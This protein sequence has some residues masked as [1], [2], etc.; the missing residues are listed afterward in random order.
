MTTSTTP[1]MTTAASE[2]T[3]PLSPFQRAALRYPRRP[4]VL[5]VELARPAGAL[6]E[7]AERALAASPELTATLRTVAGLRIPRQEPH[8]PTT[9]FSAGGGWQLTAG[10]LTVLALPRGKATRLTVRADALVADARSMELFLARMADPNGPAAPLAFFDVAAGHAAMARDG[11]LDQ[12]RQYWRAVPRLGDARSG[13]GSAAGRSDRL[14]EVSVPVEAP[15]CAR[16]ADLARAQGVEVSDMLYLALHLL[17]NRVCPD[18]ALVGR[19]TDART[20]MGAESVSG[21]FTQVVPDVADVDSAATALEML[22]AQSGRLSQHAAMAGGAALTEGTTAPTVV[23]D[24][25]T[26]WTLPEGWRLVTSFEAR[27]TALTLRGLRDPAGGLRLIANT[28]DGED[29]EPLR[30]VLHAWAETITAMTA[31]PRAPWR[32]MNLPTGNSPDR[33]A[34]GLPLERPAAEDLCAR[35][36]ALAMHDPDAPALRQGAHLLTRRQLLD[37]IGELSEAFGPLDAG[38]VVA[39]LAEPEPDLLA[40]WMAALWQSAAFLPLS[41]TEPRARIEQAIADSAASV[42]LVGQHAPEFTPPAGCRIVRAE[43]VAASPRDPGPPTPTHSDLPAYLLRTSGSTGKPKMISV[44][45]GSLNNYLRWVAEGLLA[46]GTDLPVVSSPVFDA[47]FKQLLGPQYAGGTT[48][49]LRADRTDAVQVRSELAEADRPFSLNCVPSYWAELLNADGDAGPAL[50]LRRL[51]LG[52]EPVSDALVRRTAE[53]YPDAELWNLY[54]P[55]ETTATATAGRLLPGEPVHV[56]SAVAGAF[57]AVADPD[58]R[59]LPR[60]MHG[61]VWIAGPGRASGYLGDADQSPFDLLRSGAL[62]VPA[63]RTG[64]AGWIDDAGRLHLHG[65]LDGQLKLHGWRIE[66]AE[67]ERVAE[68]APGVLSAAVVLDDRVQPPSLRLFVLGA[69]EE[70]AVLD[71]LRGLLPTPMLP[72][73]VTRVERFPRTGSGKL[74]RRRLLDTISHRSEASPEDYGPLELAIATV[75]RQVVGG[76]WPH[77]D[78][79]FF[80]AGGHSVLLARLVNQLRTLGHTSLSLRKVVRNPS[81]NSI[82]ELIRTGTQS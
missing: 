44:R 72:A 48:W 12:E 53:R 14:V 81:V 13:L 58:G 11:E 21:L 23:F 82:A 79:D 65:R 28:C 37:R 60:G 70:S 57:V 34:P 64:D 55:T 10:G 78:E 76:G 52:G 77:P 74:D 67:I 4:L 16:L 2:S 54:G 39:V 9:R 73:S 25:R 66:P 49:L 31:N 51:L 61:E 5:T 19:L 36:Y 29:P 20:L 75:W 71:V 33:P 43:D 46:D 7:L 42:V 35:L 15:S 6:A 69:A 27:S 50:R 68:S 38:A 59:A 22:C 45:R 1:E 17:A 26:D 62:S 24:P 80:S 41:P 3:Y 63:Y 56:G 40:A 30:V 8:L 47:S 32:T 18:G